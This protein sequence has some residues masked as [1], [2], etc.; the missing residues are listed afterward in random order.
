[1]MVASAAIKPNAAILGGIDPWDSS[2]PLADDNV[3]VLLHKEI[4]LL[5]GN[6][7][8]DDIEDYNGLKL[9]F[10]MPLCRRLK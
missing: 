1:M 3:E 5:A 2:T 10:S 4:C 6:G 8:A 7:F 9:R